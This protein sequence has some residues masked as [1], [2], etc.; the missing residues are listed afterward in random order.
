MLFSTHHTW[1]LQRYRSSFLGFVQEFLEVV[2]ETSGIYAKIPG[3]H[4]DDILT[5]ENMG[6]DP[7]NYQSDFLFL[8]HFV[9]LHSHC[10]H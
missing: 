6:H 2:K 7:K 10:Y 1:E 3:K 9:L 8:T 5:I 4:S